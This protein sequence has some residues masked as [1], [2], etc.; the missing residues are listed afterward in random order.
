MLAIPNLRASLWH[1]RHARRHSLETACVFRLLTARSC[2]GA[3]AAVVVAPPAQ[4]P[5]NKIPQ[6]PALAVVRP[7]SFRESQEQVGLSERQEGFLLEKLPKDLEESGIRNRLL[8]FGVDLGHHWSDRVLLMRSRLGHSIGRALIAVPDHVPHVARGFPKGVTYRSVDRYDIEAFV[9]QCERLVCFSEDLR[10]LARPENF[11]RTIT[12]TEIP[13]AYGR[14]DVVHV[15]KQH[16]DVTV[17]PQDV[18]FRFKRWGRQSDTCYVVCPDIHAADHCIAQIQELAVPKRAA[19]GSLFGAAFLW[20]SRSSLFLCDPSLDFSLHSSKFCVFTTG[21]QEDMELEEFLAV[22]NQMKFFPGKAE[23][24]HIEA[25]NS[26]A[27]FMYFNN[28]TTT[29]ATMSKMK[30]LKRRW[31]MKVQMPLFAYPRRVDVHRQHEDRYE[32][33]DSADD[34][35]VDEPVMY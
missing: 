1:L 14:Q 35:E 30:K 29:K 33:A 12:I 20:S 7:S 15:I 2:S 26:S 13:S 16:C 3:A 27:F 18:V 32:D 22:M 11:L 31:R 19:Y 9:E 6:R 34:S 28:M 5:A 8:D 24:H 23:K 10:R 21:W 4:S 17:A 25:D